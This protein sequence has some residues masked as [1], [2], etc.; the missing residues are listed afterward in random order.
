MTTFLK[1]DSPY[2]IGPP[3]PPGRFYGRSRQLSEFFRIMRS[4]TLQPLRIL[5]LRRSGKTS[6]LQYISQRSVYAAEPE[7]VARPTVIAY[8]NLQGEVASPVEF[9]AVV[10]EA[11]T[12]A[13]YRS[14]VNASLPD[15]PIDFRAFKQWMQNI[16]TA[17]DKL[18]V[19][20][21][22]DEFE[23][24]AESPTFDQSFFGSLRALASGP[25]LF[26]RFTWVVASYTDLH[27]LNQKIENSVKT[28]PLFNI[29]YPSPIILGGMEPYEIEQ[30]IRAPAQER[31]V[32]YSVEEVEAITQLSGPLPY[33]VQ[34]AA[35]QWFITRSPATPLAD[36]RQKVLSQ[37]LDASG[38]VSHQLES[39]W[40][41]LTD[42]ECELISL[43][44]RSELIISTNSAPE[45][46]LLQ[47]GL[48]CEKDG[49]VKISGQ[50]FQWWLENNLTRLT[51]ET[52]REE[53]S[54][55]F[56]SSNN[57]QSGGVTIQANTVNIRDVTGR[58]KIIS[59]VEDV[60]EAGRSSNA[61]VKLDELRVDAAVPSAVHTG[62]PFDLAVSVRR[63]L[64]PILSE[65]ELAITKS[66]AVQVAWHKS[67]SY[68]QLRLH[69]KAADC[70]ID[71]PDQVPI[72]LYPDTDSPVFYFSLTPKCTGIFSIIVRIYQE[73][74]CWGSTL[75]RTLAQEQPVG[76]VQ[77]LVSSSNLESLREQ[78]SEAQDN[79]KLIQERID[80]YVLSTDVP[81]QLVKEQWNLQKRIKELE[82]RLSSG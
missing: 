32:H 61:Q 2:I 82:E 36:C 6:F 35:N 77:F 21:L 26:W 8:V 79:L 24:L 80:A 53:N 56:S 30:L 43:V 42:E 3:V 47:F 54:S 14:R 17:D 48:L 1:S 11:I 71:G 22:L 39:Y 10:A 70:M 38:H 63:R 75:I 62:R 31:G 60:S 34:A 4:Q 59:A 81:L 50:A 41:H 66:G 23:V 44:V 15:L 20:V 33:F 29:F 27:L 9:F 51:T 55:A 19:I 72:R 69:V 49:Q 57:S 78:L 73:D 68:I 40:K 76:Q 45:Q 13:L 5:G 16:L 67:E 37:L 7:V 18:R 58:D 25:S 65:P 28:S 46:K 12:D 52:G 74:E 64:S